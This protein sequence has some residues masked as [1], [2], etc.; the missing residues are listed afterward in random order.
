MFPYT[1]SRAHSANRLRDEMDRLFDGFFGE[2]AGWTPSD[3]FAGQAYPPLNIW[4][5]EGNVYAEA[6][7]PGLTMD[8]L[9]VLVTGNELSIKGERKP[10]TETNVTFHR[11]ERGVGAFRRVVRLPLGIDADR[12]Q[13]TLQDGV[14]TITLPKAEAARARKIEVK[15]LA[16]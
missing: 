2:R 16:K 5:D 12:V 4:E 11:G 1:T 13:A 6:E 10:Q 9:E 8:D 14:L 15:A 7:L 3:L